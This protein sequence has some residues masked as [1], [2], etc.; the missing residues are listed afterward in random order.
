MDSDK[1]KQTD[2][3]PAERQGGADEAIKDDGWS[4]VALRKRKKTPEGD[5]PSDIEPQGR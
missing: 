3:A 5:T 4:K 2:D 1:D